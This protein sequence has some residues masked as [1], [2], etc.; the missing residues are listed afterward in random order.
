[1]LNE[2]TRLHV[3][4]GNYARFIRAYV[5]SVYIKRFKRYQHAYTLHRI[6]NHSKTLIARVLES[7]YFYYSYVTEFDK[8]V[9]LSIDRHIILYS[10]IIYAH[11]QLCTLLVLTY[12]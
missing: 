5:H 2:K 6:V 11:R 12:I 3:Q 8:R 1:M 9:F 7:M 4:K 10:S